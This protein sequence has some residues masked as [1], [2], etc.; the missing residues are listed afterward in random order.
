MIKSLTVP[1]NVNRF[2]MTFHVKNTSYIMHLD[3]KNNPESSHNHDAHFGFTQDHS[4]K[5]H[6]LLSVL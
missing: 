6:P 5:Q 1:L 2:A 4:G 3:H